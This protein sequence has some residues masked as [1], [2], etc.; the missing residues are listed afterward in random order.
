MFVLKI[1]T[2]VQS[3]GKR[4]LAIDLLSYA[5]AKKY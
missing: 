5:E 3:E 4:E 2:V 1:H